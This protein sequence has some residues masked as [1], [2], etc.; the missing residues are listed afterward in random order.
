MV[1]AP[2]LQVHSQQYNRF[3]VLIDLQFAA[4]VE[5]KTD[6]LDVAFEFCQMICETAAVPIV[7]AL[8]LKISSDFLKRAPPQRSKMH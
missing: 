7:Q 4:A 5:M 8:V 3:S 1:P 2:P 6:R